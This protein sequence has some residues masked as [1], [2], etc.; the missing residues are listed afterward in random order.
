VKNEEEDL[1]GGFMMPVG[2]NNGV[3]QLKDREQGTE[4]L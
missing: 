4:L 3:N 1:E 2:K